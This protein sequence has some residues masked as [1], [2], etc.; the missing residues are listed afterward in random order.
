MKKFIIVALMGM[1]CSLACASVDSDVGVLKPPKYAIISVNY[2]N[3]LPAVIANVNP[4]EVSS[5]RMGQ[6]IEMIALENSVVANDL[7]GLNIARDAYRST[8]LCDG[9]D[10]GTLLSDE[11][12]SR[13]CFELNLYKSP[14]IN[15]AY[16][17]NIPPIKQC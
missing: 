9:N 15:H 4:A 5:A 12:T 8:P 1:V 10:A 13:L 6:L 17:Q 16:F 3:L 7:S 2:E 11:R 14:G